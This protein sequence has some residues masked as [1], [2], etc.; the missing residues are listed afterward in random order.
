MSGASRGGGE[1]LLLSLR[2]LVSPKEMF[3]CFRMASKPTSSTEFIISFTTEI[4]LS[5]TQTEASFRE[6]ATS[7]LETPGS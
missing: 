3:E 5:V 7:A 4:L 2:D 6:K 1:R